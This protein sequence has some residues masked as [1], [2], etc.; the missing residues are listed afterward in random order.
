M[1]SGPSFGRPEEMERDST[2]TVVV[3]DG[4]RG[5]SPFRAIFRVNLATGARTLVS[6]CSDA[7]C[8][9]TVG[10]GPLFSDGVIGLGVL[11]GGDLVV[12]DGLLR[13]LFAVDGATG[14]RSVLSGC[15][16][17]SCTSVA[18]AGTHFTD[19]LGIAT[20]PEPG[21]PLGLAACGIL[22]AALARRQRERAE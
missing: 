8:S 12:S 4:D 20:I 5:V 19:P 13:A 3:V 17:A 10:S 9:G 1:G 14:D 21:L 16:D 15:V 18:G 22:L 7:T 6:G 2:S 11:S